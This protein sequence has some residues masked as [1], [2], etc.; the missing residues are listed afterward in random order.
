[1][2]NQE[3]ASI[4]TRWADPTAEAVDAFDCGDTE[5]NA[6]FRTRR[7]FSDGKLSPPTYEFVVNGSTV[8]FAAV[9]ERKV[10]HP[11]DSATE[12][13][14]Y[15]VIFAFGINTQFHGKRLGGPSTGTYAVAALQFVESLLKPKHVG[16]T[17]WVR[18]NNA[19]AIACYKKFGFVADPGGARARGEGAPHLS[20][21]KP[22]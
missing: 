21:R 22:R 4:V 3:P 5:V 9:D 18:A 2:S 13:M 8:G 14:K 19:R 1:M 16:L 10:E 12:K 15:L 17:L 11:S 6:F 20:M 7:W